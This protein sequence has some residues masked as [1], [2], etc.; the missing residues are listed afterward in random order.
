MCVC[1]RAMFGVYALQ[2]D[3]NLMVCIALVLLFEMQLHRSRAILSAHSLA[4]PFAKHRFILYVC[5][6]LTFIFTF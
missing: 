6:I 4:K 3:V 1:V 5:F 2:I